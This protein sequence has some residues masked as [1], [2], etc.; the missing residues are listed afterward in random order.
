MR[1]SKENYKW[2][3]KVKWLRYTYYVSA[4]SEPKLSDAHFYLNQIQLWK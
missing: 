3:I 4:P 2:Y 1:D